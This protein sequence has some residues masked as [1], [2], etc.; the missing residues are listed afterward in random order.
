M[1]IKFFFDKNQGIIFR[2]YIFLKNRQMSSILRQTPENRRIH[3]TD[4]T[5]IRMICLFKITHM[6]IQKKN[7]RKEKKNKQRQTINKFG[8]HCNFVKA[9][10]K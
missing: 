9:L 7:L 8:F 10:L 3:Y 2:E 6:V 1:S 5:K 4:K